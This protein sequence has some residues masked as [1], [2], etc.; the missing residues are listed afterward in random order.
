[1]NEE[2][3]YSLS[4]SFCLLTSAPAS[5]RDDRDEDGGQFVALGTR[6]LQLGRWHN[7]SIDEQFP[8]RRDSLQRVATLCH[9]FGFASSALGFPMVHSD[10]GFRAEQLFAEQW[11]C[12]RGR[13][14]G[15]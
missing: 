4:H 12:R 11:S 15:C 2:V 9:Q 8:P 5:L 7:F 3:E 6:R 13:R 14:S 10:E 1:M